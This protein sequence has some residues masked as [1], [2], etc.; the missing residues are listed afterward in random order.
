MIIDTHTHFYD[1]TRPEDVP[2][3]NPN[4]ELLYRT[5]MPDD[6]KKLAVP[7]GVTGTVVVEASK[8]I[9]DNQWILDLAANEPF[10][11][12]FVG[13]LNP[14]DADFE[15]NLNRFSA[16]PLFRG[17]RLGGGHL[18]SL[19]NTNFMKNIEK[20]AEKE[21]T[22]DLLINPDALRNV[23]ALVEHTPTMRVMI[24][25]IA[26]VRVDGNPPDA[27]WVSAIQEVA[28]YPNV[29][30]KVSGLAEHTGQTPAPED[31]TYYTPTIDVLWKA[32][33]QDRLIYGSNWPV[34]ERFAQYKVVQ[35]IVDDYF[36]PKGD[37]VKAKFF[38]Q[39]AKT[40]YQLNVA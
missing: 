32:F 7:E 15:D 3:P 27:A 12:G 30:C 21:L 23:P 22:L 39:N 37:E 24:N 4:D 8:W 10:I 31:V 36:S 11:V 19:S 33:G 6:Y 40:A 9:E 13:N 20:L 1:P 2:W 16:N 17:I 28:R 34:S 14:N 18:Q 26:G 35:K 25:H 5:V 38:W 29:Y